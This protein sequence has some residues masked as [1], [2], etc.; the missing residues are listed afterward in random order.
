MEGIPTLM[1]K[2]NQRTSNA[3]FQELISKSVEV[4]LYIEKKIIKNSATSILAAYLLF[5]PLSL[6]YFLGGSWQPCHEE[7]EEL[8]STAS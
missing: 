8:R 6:R 4:I 2:L 7:S 1:G 5:L 3:Q